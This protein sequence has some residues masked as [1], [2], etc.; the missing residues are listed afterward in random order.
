MNGRESEDRRHYRR[1]ISSLSEAELQVLIL[2][3]QGM[4]A[5]LIAEQ[6]GTSEGTIRTQ[7]K[8]V[9]AKLKVDRMIE[10]AVMAAKAGVV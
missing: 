1:L 4:S 3:C 6:R 8:H 5:D 9:L 10:A 7:R 2:T